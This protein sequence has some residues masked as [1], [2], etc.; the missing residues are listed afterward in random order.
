M[1][2]IEFGSARTVEALRA[3]SGNVKMPKTE[4]SAKKKSLS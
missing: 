2:T 3:A 4:G 1:S